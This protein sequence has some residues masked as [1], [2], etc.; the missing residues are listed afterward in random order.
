MLD[1]TW[2]RASIFIIWRVLIDHH[3]TIC[4]PA[5]PQSSF[6]S[7]IWRGMISTSSGS[8]SAWII[9]LVCLLMIPDQYVTKEIMSNTT[10][11]ND[12]LGAFWKQYSFLNFQRV[13]QSALNIIRNAFL[14]FGGRDKANWIMSFIVDDCVKCAW[15]FSI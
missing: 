15:L 7:Q 8:H 9:S 13:Q 1:C 6:G 5:S 14:E 3:G 12:F 10:V 2:C 11:L 4:N